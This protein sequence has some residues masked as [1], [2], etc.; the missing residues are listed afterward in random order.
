MDLFRDRD[1]YIVDANLP[2]VDPGCF[3][4]DG[5]LMSTRAAS[6]QMAPSSKRITDRY[7]NTV[8][9]I[10]ML[11]ANLPVRNPLENPLEPRMSLA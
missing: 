3:D 11:M 7:H 2:R 1:Q 10:G 9:L 5:Q 6:Q 8:L 4:V